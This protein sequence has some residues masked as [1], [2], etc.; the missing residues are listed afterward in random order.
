M[1][2]RKIVPVDTSPTT[3]LSTKTFSPTGG[4]IRLISVTTTTMMP[5]HTGSKKMGRPDL[6][7]TSV[8]PVAA[9]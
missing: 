6:P 4:V 2:P 5:N 1:T 3:P 8:S 9:W 7:C